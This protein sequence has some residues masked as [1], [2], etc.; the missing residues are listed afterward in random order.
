M[1]AHGN[2]F[3]TT[4][5]G[6]AYGSGVIFEIAKGSNTITTL[7][8]FNDDGQ[9]SQS[10]LILGANGNLYGMR[11]TGGANGLGQVFELA[12]GSGTITTIASF[13]GTD[14]FYPNGTLAM[15]AN[16]NLFG[17]TQDDGAY[18]DGTLFEIASGSNAITTLVTFDGTNGLE[19][20]GTIAFGPNGTLYGTTLLRSVSSSANGPGTVWKYTASVPEPSTMLMA[21][22]SMALVT[23]FSF[24]K[25]RRS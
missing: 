21:L 5:N 6:G 4:V 16:G 14:G 22:I 19:P 12:N 18:D 7:A 20:T 25:Q 24:M 3:G 10:T 2:L 9:S 1:D 17:T 23:G 15:D 11:K 13:N 8:S